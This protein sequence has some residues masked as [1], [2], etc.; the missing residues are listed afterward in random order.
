[1]LAGEIPESVKELI[2]TTTPPKV[3]ITNVSIVVMAGYSATE[4]DIFY[5]RELPIDY[6]SNFEEH[7]KQYLM[8]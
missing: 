7:I 1:M 4:N 8:P 5:P 2:Y 6:E 3:G